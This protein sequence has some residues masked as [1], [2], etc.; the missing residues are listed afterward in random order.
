MSARFWIP[1]LRSIDWWSDSKVELAK[2]HLERIIQVLESNWNKIR[3]EVQQVA[4]AG[5][6]GWT[7]SRL[8]EWSTKALQVAH[9]REP[10]KSVVENGEFNSWHVMY[11]VSQGHFFHNHRKELP[12]TMALLEKIKKLSQKLFLNI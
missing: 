10:P 6:I 3:D 2:G 7:R 5:K 11:L 1:G 9:S 12:N 4:S 8:A